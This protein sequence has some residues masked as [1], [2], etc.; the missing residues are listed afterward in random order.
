MWAK[1]CHRPREGRGHIE[2]HNKKRE[3]FVGGIC[4]VGLGLGRTLLVAGVLQGASNLGF[5]HI[6][7][8]G[9]RLGAFNPDATANP[10]LE[11]LTWVIGFENFASGLSQTA[12]VAFLMSLCDRRYTAAQFALLTSIM[13]F[14][15]K[16]LV[17]PAGFLAEATGWPIFCLIT[18][19]AAVPGLLLLLWILRAFPK[20]WRA[21]PLKET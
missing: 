19:L 7:V 11:T 21:A 6:S 12:F 9:E 17:A 16:V 1:N 18:A 8:L 3:P 10:G 4:V 5:W 14:S 20:S 15:P 13:A 2:N